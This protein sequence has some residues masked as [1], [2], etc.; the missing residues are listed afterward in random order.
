MVGAY[1]LQAAILHE[2]KMQPVDPW[3]LWERRPTNW[4]FSQIVGR[5][6]QSRLRRVVGL[7]GLR[8]LTKLLAKR[9]EVESKGSVRDGDWRVGELCVSFSLRGIIDWETLLARFDYFRLPNLPGG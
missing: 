3:S 7:R 4:E 8:L 1:A 9:R 5:T 2:G 6:R